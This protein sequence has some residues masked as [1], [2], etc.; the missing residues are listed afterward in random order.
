[1]SGSKNK[2]C[3]VL[4]PSECST[5][6]STVG[7][8]NDL[9]DSSSSSVF[10]FCCLR[11]TTHQMA[12]AIAAIATT[13]LTAMSA[14]FFLLMLRRCTRRWLAEVWHNP[15]ERTGADP[16]RAAFLGPCGSVGASLPGLAGCRDC[17][18]V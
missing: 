11:L 7:S 4:E 16:E 3:S 12:N 10:E 14:I 2:G 13:A 9:L 17:W 5:S 15:A 8:N 18:N 1:M 6:G